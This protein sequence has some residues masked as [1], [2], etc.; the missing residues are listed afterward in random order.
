MAVKAADLIKI[1][2][3]MGTM[4]TIN[5]PLDQETAILIIEE[6]G[7]T[8]IRHKEDVL[9]EGVLIDASQKDTKPR[10]PVVTIMGHVDH[11]KTSL[12]DY[13]RKTR[14]AL[15]ETGGITQHI[16]AY[17]V[18]TDKGKITFLDTPGHEAFTACEHVALAVLILSFWWLL[19]TMA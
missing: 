18:N 16:G 3:K 1:L 19:L 11:G 5:Q 7:H 8:Y 12:L 10:A 4:A 9:E 13:I 2:M 15:A 6:M 17:S 14:V